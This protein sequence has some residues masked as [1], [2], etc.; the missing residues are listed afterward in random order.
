MQNLQHLLNKKVLHYNHIDFIELDP[1]SIPHQF[2]QQQDI[3][4][5]AF[6]AAILAWGNRKSIITSCKKL[7]NCMNNSPY[8]FIMNLDE[9]KNWQ[10]NFKT[11]VHR[12]FNSI[13]AVHLIIVLHHHYKIKNE[14]SLESAFAKY[15]TKKD[16]TI[17]NALNGFFEYCFNKNI[18]KNYPERTKKHIASPN[19]KSACKRLNMFLRW[20]VRQD[21][22]GVDFGLWKNIKSSQLIIPLDVHVINV[23]HHYGLI[24]TTK[25]NWNTAVELTN[26]LKKFDVNDPVKYDYALFSLGIVEKVGK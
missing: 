22:A 18:F 9:N 23:A 6:F 24:S 19:K 15:I 3:E 17:E 10:H 8:H 26:Y 25:A 11:F 20:M 12:T 21:G 2:T 1:I 7:M 16:T 4:I 13:D 5:A 14:K